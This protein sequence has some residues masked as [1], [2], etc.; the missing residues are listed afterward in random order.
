MLIYNIF[1][2]K[3]FF[4]IK[5]NG[6]KEKFNDNKL[7][8]ILLWSVDGLD[9][10]DIHKILQHFNFNYSMDGI[11]TRQI[12]ESLIESSLNLV[13]IEDSDYQFVASRLLTYWMRKNVWGGKNPPRLI[14]L[15]RSN[16]SKGY[17]DKFLLEKYSI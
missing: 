8:K 2:N 11:S 14:D 3:D 12:H 17:Y 16:I 9:N 6:D 4:V 10:V 5:R 13:S 7:K 15:I 1:M